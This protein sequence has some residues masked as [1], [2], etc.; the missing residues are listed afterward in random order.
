MIRNYPKFRCA[1]YSKMVVC[2]YRAGTLL[3]WEVV[4]TEIWALSIIYVDL[5]W[6]RREMD[7]MA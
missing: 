2:R 6:A 5:C 7:E 4:G 1:V 3:G